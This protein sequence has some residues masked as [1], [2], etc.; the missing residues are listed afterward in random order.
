MSD[1]LQPLRIFA[2]HLRDPRSPPPP[3]LSSERL[4]LYR[5]LFLRNVEGLLA[6]TFPVCRRLLGEEGFRSLSAAFFASHPSRTPYFPRLPEEFLA[7][8]AARADTPSWLRELAHYEWAE[9]ALAIDPTDLAAVRA[10]PGDPFAGVPVAN[11]LAW[12]VGYRWPVHR[13]SAVPERDLPPD[14]PTWLLL[15]RGRDDWVRFFELS[16]WDAALLGRIRERP[17]QSG[18]EHLEALAEALGQPREAIH[19]AGRSALSALLR[20]EAILG[21]APDPDPARPPS[22]PCC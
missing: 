16:P 11:P 2:R 1:P 19:E 5:E 12:A 18:R 20:C 15:L 10:A 13:L 7:F 9:L 21:V 4:A 14:R 3:G 17:E 6:G 22:R 8:L